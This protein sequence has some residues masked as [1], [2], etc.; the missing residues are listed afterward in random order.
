[1][2]AYRVTVVTDSS[3]DATE[4]TDPIDGVLH[5]VRYTKT[6]YAAGVDFVITGETSGQGV[7]SED[8][9]NAS[10]QRAPRMATH[11]VD[12]TAALYAAAGEAVNAP[13]ALAGER[14]KIVVASGGDTK[15]GLF[16][17]IVE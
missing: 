1:M 10:A 14:I 11:H 8:D 17:F 13:I 4:Y 3:G 5:S 2:R 7:W 6:D 12:G 15:T 16:T 9:V